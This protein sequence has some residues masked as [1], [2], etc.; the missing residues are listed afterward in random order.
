VSGEP[1]DPAAWAASTGTPAGEPRRLSEPVV[2][3]AGEIEVDRRSLAVRVPRGMAAVAVEG[4]LRDQGLTLGVFPERYEVEAVGVLAAADAPGAGA[5]GPGFRSL[6]LSEDDATL[7]LAVAVRPEAQAGRAFRCGDFPAG[8]ELLRRAAQEGVLPQIAFVADA[9]AAGLLLGVAG[10]PDDARRRLGGSSALIVLIAAG[11]HG[12]AAVR[13]DDAVAVLADE[14]EDLGQNVARAWAQSRY[15]LALHA[16]VL[17]AAGY[18]LVTSW[19]WHS[20]STVDDAYAAAT[21][22]AGHAGT[23]LLGCD[24]H[25]GRLV[26]RILRPSGE[27][28][29][30]H[31]DGDQPGAAEPHPRDPL[32]QEAGR[33]RGGD[34]D[35][36]LTHGGDRPG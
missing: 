12:E 24:P 27:R 8:G 30:R 25:G 28:E 22:L 15:D 36:R 19:R 33:E 14:A 9:A 23:E 26:T 20:W 5:S 21:G 4:R 2:T 34:D 16:R 31:A 32:A 10:D 11:R 17:A 18:D 6:V 35:A 7:L 29:R 3:T 1:F 13:L